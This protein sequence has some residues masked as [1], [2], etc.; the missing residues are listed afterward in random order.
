M[1]MAADV[2][3]VCHRDTPLTQAMSPLKLYEYLAAGLPVVAT[4]LEPM[5]DVSDRCLL[6]A[7]GDDWAPAV[8]KAAELGPDEPDHLARFR[9]QN[10]WSNRYLDWRGAALGW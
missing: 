6:V 10:D 7:A 2:G 3:L 5:R 8:R 9:A 4:D 1:M